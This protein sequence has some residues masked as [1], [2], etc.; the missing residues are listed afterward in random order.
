MYCENSEL[1]I[2]VIQLSCKVAGDY[3]ERKRNTGY[4]FKASKA[5]IS[6]GNNL[7]NDK[8]LPPPKKYIQYIHVFL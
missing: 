7:N 2:C 6:E 3:W 1:E 5:C 4:Y 8:I